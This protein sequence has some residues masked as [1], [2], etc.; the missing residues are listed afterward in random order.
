MISKI[1]QVHW[2]SPVRIDACANVRSTLHIQ[3]RRT[4]GWTD[5]D[6]NW[7]KHS[8]GQSAQVME[9]GVRLAWAAQV[10]RAIG[11]VKPSHASA[12]RENKREVQEHMNETWW[13][14]CREREVCSMKQKQVAES[15][16]DIS[17]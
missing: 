17:R 2:R 9:V 7:Y 3:R 1:T 16:T 10:Q 4:H 15:Q 13:L 12:K 6:P 14:R 5:L 11:A 8:L